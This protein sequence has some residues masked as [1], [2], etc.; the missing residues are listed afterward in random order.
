MDHGL[1]PVGGDRRHV[2]QVVLEQQL[3]FGLGVHASIHAPE[4]AEEAEACAVPRESSAM[5][6]ARTGADLASPTGRPS[7]R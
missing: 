7:G 3:G 4:G 6:R 5:Q 2:A 1:A